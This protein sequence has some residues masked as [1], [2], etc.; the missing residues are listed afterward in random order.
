M[1]ASVIETEGRPVTT[2]GIYNSIGFGYLY[3][4]HVFVSMGNGFYK[5]SVNDPFP[6]SHFLDDAGEGYRKAVSQSKVHHHLI[7]DSKWID[8]TAYAVT[9]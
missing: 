4:G 3:A 1:K 6:V 7:H 8:V 2:K 9:A 5:D